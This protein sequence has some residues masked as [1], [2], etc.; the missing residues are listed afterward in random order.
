MKPNVYI[1]GQAGTTGL[2]I[3][4]RLRSRTDVNLLEIDPARRKD[5]KARRE[6][7]AAADL[8]FFCLPDDAAREAA[9]LAEGLSTRIIDASTA[10]RTTPGWTYGLPEL[11]GRR[12]EIK[13]ARLVANPGC[14][15]TGFI[16]AVKPLVEGG[17]LPADYPLTVHALSG[18]TG[19]GSKA[20][21]QYESED[22]PTELKSPRHYAL[23]LTHKHLPEM[24]AQCGLTRAPVFLPIICDFPQGMAVAVPLGLDLLHA[25][26]DDLR[27]CLADY[28][29][30]ERLIQVA[31][32]AEPDFLASNH[33]AGRDDLELSVWGNETQGVI[34]ARLDNLG[35]GAAGAAV[36]NMNLML[37]FDQYTG[38]NLGLSGGIL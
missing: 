22:R 12:E 7:M 36:Q 18:Y 3:F 37:G 32:E 10:H 1:D 21:A 14:Y 25:T 20:I 8:T 31:P 9:Q 6:L 16:T 38:L 4:D 5:P 26:V 19:G 2:Q 13:K 24:V 17:L 35:K 11:H 27:T 23:G 29:A 30:G 28:Y 34:I 33:L 15:A